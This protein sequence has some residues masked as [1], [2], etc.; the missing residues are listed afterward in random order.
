MK[1]AMIFDVLQYGGIERVGIDYAKLLVSQGNSVTVY[2]LVP[3]LDDMGKDFEKDIDIVHISF[4]RFM[5][6]EI[7]SKFVKRG[8]GYKQLYPCAYADITILDIIYKIILKV[9]GK[10]SE[11]YDTVIGFSVHYN[12]LILLKK[13][14]QTSLSI[15]PLFEIVKYIITKKWSKKYDETI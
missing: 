9:C 12:D 4:F 7:Y 14:I 2:N 10:L 15:N 1:I 6:P 8:Y 3:N 11:S 5:S 13:I